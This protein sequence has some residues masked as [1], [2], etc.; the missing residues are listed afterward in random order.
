MI[1]SRLGEDLERREVETDSGEHKGEHNQTDDDLGGVLALALLEQAIADESQN[2]RQQ[3]GQH[4]IEL[5]LEHQR[6]TLTEGELHGKLEL[7]GRGDQAAGDHDAQHVGEVAQTVEDLD[8]RLLDELH[9]HLVTLVQAEVLQR[10]IQ[11]VDEQEHHE[12]THN[13]AVVDAHRC[14]DGAGDREPGEV[15][16]GVTKAGEGTHEGGLDADDGVLL[17]LIRG[18]LQGGGDAKD[19]GDRERVG[20]EVLEV[21]LHGVNALLLGGVLVELL[22]DR[23]K[24]VG[25]GQRLHALVVVRELATLGAQQDLV[26]GGVGDLTH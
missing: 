15:Q 9:A 1:S 26:Q 13:G 10:P 23:G 5:V 6:V 4:L 18:L 16:Q 11:Q 3:E 21:A 22:E 24:A 20:V 7:N 12:R 2:D 25:Q 19:E 17:I 8:A 14:A